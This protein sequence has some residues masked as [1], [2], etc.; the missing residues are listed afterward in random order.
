[1]FL[2]SYLLI[3][4]F[5]HV[6]FVGCFE[7]ALQAILRGDRIPHNQFF[8]LVNSWIFREKS[9]FEQHARNRF[10]SNICPSALVVLMQK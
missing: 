6:T 3:N 1:M 7:I 9:K 4:F 5:K 2:L 8:F 10:S